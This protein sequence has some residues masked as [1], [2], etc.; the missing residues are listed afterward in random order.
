M[1]KESAKSEHMRKTQQSTFE[2]VKK[3]VAL[4]KN[5]IVEKFIDN[6]SIFLR[7]GNGF[8]QSETKKS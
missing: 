6:F 8:S 7:V 1:S 2:N 4:L 3:N 5:T